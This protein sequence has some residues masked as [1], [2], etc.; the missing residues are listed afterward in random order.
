VKR[1]AVCWLAV[2]A[3]AFMP[4]TVVAGDSPATLYLLHCSGCHGV[5]GMGEWRAD[6]PPLPPYVSNFLRDPQGRL[7][8][9]NVG[10]VISS[11]LSDADTALL[12]NWVLERFGDGKPLDASSRFDAAEIG[13]LRRNRVADSVLLRRT[14]ASRLEKKGFPLAEYPWP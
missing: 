2:I 4:P 14:I 9:A 6:V 8:I 5:D 3:A 11:G 7:Y 10:G 12:L 13:A 1:R